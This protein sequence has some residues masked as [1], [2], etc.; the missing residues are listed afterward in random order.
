MI[1]QQTENP[2]LILVGTTDRHTSTRLAQ[3]HLAELERLVATLGYRVFDRVIFR[4]DQVRVSTFIGSGQVETLTRMVEETGA[5]GVTFDDE[6][7]PSQQRNLESRTGAAIA[8][9]HEIILDIFCDHATTHEARLQVE[10]ARLKYALPRLKRAWTHLSRQRGG[11]RG[12]RGGGETQLEVD[13]RR[14][15]ERI[16]RIDRQLRSVGTHRQTIRNRRESV[17]VPTV[18][19]VGYTNAGKSSLLN[20]LTGAQANVR[21]SLFETLD[22]KTT[23][24]TLDNGMELLVTDTVG[25]IRKLPHDLVDAFHSTLEETVRADLLLH[26]VDAASSQLDEEL[27]TTR[28]VLDEIGASARPAITV[29]NKIDLL[30][31]SPHM[32][33]AG[34]E[35]AVWLSCRSGEGIDAL[36]ERLADYFSDRFH[37]QRY[38]LPANRWDLVA[39]LHREAR[40]HDQEVN[41][42]GVIVHAAVPEKLRRALTRFA[43][44]GRSSS[45][46]PPQLS[47]ADGSS[48]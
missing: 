47:G 7:S 11:V 32:P 15:Q 24:L 42:T 25:F 43:V 38:E 44:P 18:A 46:D 26:V 16:A 4:C 28:S 8:D 27:E 1:E 21:D 45:W 48:A 19:L 3:E 34:I 23:R 41:G 10:K 39:L 14:I 22:P 33:A 6:L 36:R 31:H 17:P 2:G 5:Q 35:N 29:C 20:A 9:R 37:S 13:R 12:S 40:V 30:E